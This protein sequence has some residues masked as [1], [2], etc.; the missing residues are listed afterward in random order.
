MS[1]KLNSEDIEFI[2]TS[3]ILSACKACIDSLTKPSNLRK[4][5]EKLLSAAS[6]SDQQPT[7]RLSTIKAV[8]AYLVNHRDINKDGGDIWVFQ[9]LR[10]SR[11]HVAQA[12]R[13]KRNPEL[14]ARLDGIRRQLEEQEYLRMTAN[15][16]SYS[17]I[18][19]NR[20]DQTGIFAAAVPGVRSGS[21][22]AG[23][24]DVKRELAA[25]N[26]QISV[27]IN[28][29]FSGLGVGFAVGYASYTVTLE[30]GWRVLIGL[31]AAFFVM[32]A[33]TW[34]FVFAGTRGRKKRLPQDLI[35]N[36]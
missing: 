12:Q 25:V 11:I 3:R 28:I 29:L 20:K 22:V 30:M 8:S 32:L 5:L 16:G 33:E 35:K 4:D 19:L 26:Q 13:P 10:G 2:V 6:N 23:P 1:D 34:L 17:N 31:A 9:I 18:M 27:I 36:Q 15:V 21:T 24:G 7:I 14:V